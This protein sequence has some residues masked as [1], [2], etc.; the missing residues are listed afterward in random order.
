MSECTSV[1]LCFF[2][3]YLLYFSSVD[4]DFGS[5]VVTEIFGGLNVRTSARKHYNS[6]HVYSIELSIEAFTNENR[7]LLLCESPVLY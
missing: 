7:I 6:I 1:E 4:G 5:V 2:C 3:S